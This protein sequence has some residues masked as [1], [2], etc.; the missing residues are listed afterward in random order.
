MESE[1]IIKING[2]EP[3][4]H[5]E[6]EPEKYTGFLIMVKEI[7]LNELNTGKTLEVMMPNQLEAEKL[8]NELIIFKIS[9]DHEFRIKVEDNYLFASK[10]FIIKTGN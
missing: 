9:N 8:L 1:N 10:Y 2:I 6:N 7:I 4:L 5:L 3:P